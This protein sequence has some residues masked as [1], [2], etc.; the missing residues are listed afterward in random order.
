MRF[1]H[2][3][4]GHSIVRISTNRRC[5]KAEAVLANKSEDFIAKSRILTTVPMANSR[6]MTQ[7]RSW[8]LIE[9]MFVYIFHFHLWWSQLHCICKSI[10]YQYQ[11]YFL[12]CILIQGFRTGDFWLHSH[13]IF[14]P[15]TRKFKRVGGVFGGL[16]RKANTAL[17]V[18]IIREQTRGY[19]YKLYD[20]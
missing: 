20:G 9:E 14:S 11:L 17:S 18:S 7:P 8:K 15:A 6:L 16:K 10:E 3:H 19:V 2:R 13:Y 12:M 4:F 5:K 1:W